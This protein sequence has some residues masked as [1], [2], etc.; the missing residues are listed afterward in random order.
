MCLRGGD[1]R[2]YQTAVEKAGCEWGCTGVS[3]R[4]DCFVL[5]SRSAVD[6]EDDVVWLEGGPDEDCGRGFG[7]IL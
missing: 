5:V 2:Q 6:A 4:E 1:E 7:I 3:Q